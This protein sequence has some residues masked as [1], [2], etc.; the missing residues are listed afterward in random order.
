MKT[1]C[2]VFAL[3]ALIM[4]VILVGGAGALY[5]SGGVF[6]IPS[7]PR[8]S[9]DPVDGHRAQQKL[10]ELVLRESRHSSRQDSV[11]LTEPELNAFLARHLAQSQKM[12][13]SGLVVKVTPGLIEVQGQTR[14]KTLLKGFP[15]SVLLVYLPAYAVERPVW[16]TL[17]GT[18]EVRRGRAEIGRPSGRLRV[19]EFRLGTQSLGPWILSFMLGPTER[20]LLRWRV[21][22]N[23]DNITVQ[24]GKVVITTRK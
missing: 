16:V 17:T 10:L 22:A 11:V 21:P 1:G 2:F 9:Y 6:D 20:T 19:S 24:Q 8:A 4:G 14:L 13:F 3:L 23:V 5:F 7:L 15:F 12:P 18:I